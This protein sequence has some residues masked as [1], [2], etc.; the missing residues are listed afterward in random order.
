MD[1]EY[2]PGTLARVQ[3]I[4]TN[5]LEVVDRICRKHGLTYW[6]DGGTCLGAVRHKG[7]IPWDDDIDVGMPMDDFL[8][9]EELAKT[10]LPEGMSLHIMKSDPTQYVLWGKLYQEKTT[11]IES[12]AEQAGCDECVFIDVFPYIRLDER[13][14]DHGVGHLR[15]TQ[16][17]TK[18]I[19]IYRIKDPNVLKSLS[20]RSVAKVI[21]LAAHGVLRV[22]TNQDKLRRRFERACVAKHPGEWW[23]NPSAA[24]PYPFHKTT[25]MDPVELPFEDLTVYAP[26][27]WDR[28]C[29]DL[30]NDYMELPPEGQ[31]KSHSPLIL[32]VG[33]GKRYD[34]RN[35]D[36]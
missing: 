8:R 28:F 30:Y 32:D 21:W 34:M 12:D 13:R 35:D 26:R 14:G 3:Q 20:W 2:P 16:F 4:E 27:D 10:E 29:R 31:R 6:I 7:F 33:D 19:Y 17:W 5:M 23:G 18:L 15:R 36:R 24:R 22:V 25:L 11:F 9:F 1:R